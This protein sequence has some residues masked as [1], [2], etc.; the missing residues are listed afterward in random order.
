[1]T[2]YVLYGRES[3]APSAPVP[4]QA[5]FIPPTFGEGEILGQNVNI[6][7]GPGRGFSVITTLHAPLRVRVM[8]FVEGWYHVKSSD[9]EG[10]VFGAYLKPLNFTCSYEL[11]MVNEPYLIVMDENNTA[12]VLPRGAKLLLKKDTRC[13][14]CGYEVILPDGRRGTVDPDD[15]SLL[16]SSTKR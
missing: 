5:S 6:R 7:R 16:T 12:I 2:I 11:G 8:S 1:M 4:A 15:V 9:G 10:F 3:H 13:L 14:T